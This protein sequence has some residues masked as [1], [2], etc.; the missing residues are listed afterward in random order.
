MTPLTRAEE[1]SGERCD[2]LGPPGL[3]CMRSWIFSASR[4]R[5]VPEVAISERSSVKLSTGDHSRGSFTSGSRIFK[6]SD[7]KKILPPTARHFFY[8][9]YCGPRAVTYF[10]T[11]IASS[12]GVCFCYYNAHYDLLAG[13]AGKNCNTV[14]FL[15]V[16]TSEFTSLLYLNIIHYLRTLIL[17]A[18]ILRNY[19]KKI[20]IQ[21]TS[22]ATLQIVLPKQ[23]AQMK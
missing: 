18:S 8:Y 1:A 14:Y 20:W 15:Q 9:Y 10:N 16:C 12:V 2:L 23:Q 6:V 22:W 11:V 3:S 17:P 21:T 13:H 4:F 7:E 5:V 19:L